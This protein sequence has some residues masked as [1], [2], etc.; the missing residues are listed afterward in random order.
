LYDPK[1]DE[2]TVKAGYNIREQEGDELTIRRSENPIDDAALRG[3]IVYVDDA[4]RDPRIQFAE[5]ARRLGI[6][7][8]LAAG[9]IYRKEP[10][11]VLRVYANHRKRFRGRQRNL[12]RAVASQSAIAVA[13]ARLLDQRLRSA[14]VER[15]L[16]TAGE[17][18]SRMIRIAPPKHPRIEPALLFEPSSHVGG[19]FCD[20]FEL[21]DGRLAAVVGDVTGHGVPA[22]LV[23]ASA[24]GARRASARH[25]T[26]LA[27]LVTQ[28]NDHVWR[29]TTSS[30]FV[31]LLLVAVDPAASQ[32]HYVNAGNEPLLIL[33]DGKIL[34]TD[35]ADLVLGVDPKQRYNE[36]TLDL[37]RDDFILLYTDGVVEA[38]DFEG[39]FFG[40]D[41]LLTALG[42]YGT[43]PPDQAL[44][45]I[46]W[47]I[48]R[49]VGLAEQ[50]DDLTMVGLRVAN[51]ESA[52]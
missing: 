7:S 11:G 46:R 6:V 30:E 47:D 44:G 36:H 20:I 26:S 33:R 34:Q 38:M 8:G 5:E 1:T 4:T 23:M 37:K 22:A 35:Q 51:R 18:Q 45:N 42:L 31:T 41:R 19:D 21:P 49:F 48:R 3:E 27:E 40:R 43:M 9:M 13:N 17:V 28:L 10:I 50:S 52:R 29:E 14:V 16:K 24:R 32:L 15:Q 39:R 25:C 12:L 2:L